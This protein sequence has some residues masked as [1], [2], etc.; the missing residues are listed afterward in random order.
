M[1]FLVKLMRHHIISY[2]GF[3]VEGRV[4]CICCFVSW[5]CS[6]WQWFQVL[7]HFY[8]SAAWLRLLTALIMLLHW[9]LP[10]TLVFKHT[11]DWSFHICRL[12]L[13]IFNKTSTGKIISFTHML[14][15]VPSS[16]TVHHVFATRGSTSP[17]DCCC[18]WHHTVIV[19]I[20]FSEY[21]VIKTEIDWEGPFMFHLT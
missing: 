19:L 11:Y 5:Q 20:H 18:Q 4:A 13:K 16:L 14:L 9:F 3:L 8:S 10:S 7:K 1:I 21:N 6:Y 12:Y 17:C 2:R 15:C